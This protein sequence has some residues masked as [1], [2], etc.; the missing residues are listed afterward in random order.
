MVDVTTGRGGVSWTIQ[1]GGSALTEARMMLP[2]VHNAAN[3][4][5]AV[6]LATELGVN[7]QQAAAALATDRGVARRF[8]LRGEARGVTFVD[9]YAHLPS[10]VAAALAAAAGGGWDRVVAVFQ[11]HRYSRTEALWST[12]ADAFGDADLLVV[13]GIYSAGEAPRPG[14]S[15]ELILQ[16]VLETHPGRPA[17]YV[18]ALEDVAEALE[19]LLQPGDLCLTLGAGDLTTVPQILLDRWT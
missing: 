10:E 11:P 17:R 1:R 9:D 14:I 16:A 12:F 15:G 2:G 4:T 13:T 7:P 18:E 19:G 5:A 3:A 8:E 6:V